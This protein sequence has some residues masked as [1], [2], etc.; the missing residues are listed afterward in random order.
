MPAEM[1]TEPFTCFL[2][3]KDDAGEIRAGLAR[4]P[5]AA[6]P[7]GDVLIR[8][9]W[10]SLNF[11][12][13][14][15][16][17]GHPGVAGKLP[18][19]PGIDA[20]GTV[21]ES[22]AEDFTVGQE[23]IVTSY[24]LGAGRWGGWAEYIRV[25]AD[26]VIPLPVGFTMSEAMSFGTAG[27]TAA[28]SVEALVHNEITPDLGEVLVSGATGGV[29]CIAVQL[30]AKLGYQVVAVTGKE[31]QHEWL[32]KLGAGRIVSRGDVT[33]SSSRPL[34]STRWAGAIDTVGG[35]MLATILRSTIPRG[36]VTACGLVGGG[37]LSLT[38]YPFILRGVTLAGIDSAWYPR[39]KR[40]KL[41]EQLAGEWKLD[42]PNDLVTIVK[43]S[44]IEESV[45][46]I[47]AGEIVGRV[48]VEID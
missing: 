5:L 7:E 41:W 14:L 31:N 45:Q 6:L 38:V 37:D 43:L 40:I 35:E 44:D 47:L 16:A 2:V 27:F 29:G 22:Q 30:L 13:A 18:H 25:P 3:E 4:R 15:A 9:G 28:M 11:K 36:C 46:R 10:S 39:G 34:L 21:V 20:A 19:V 8:V 23:V 48:V 26:W 42:Q 32:R 33:D 1:T 24:D 12:D 17:T